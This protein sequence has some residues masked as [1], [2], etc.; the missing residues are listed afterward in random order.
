MILLV[1]FDLKYVARKTFKGSV[2]SD[3]CAENPIKG[4]GDKEDF[5][6]EGILDIELG[7]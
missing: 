1:E 4:E 5:T 7:A 3:F 6:D 2:T